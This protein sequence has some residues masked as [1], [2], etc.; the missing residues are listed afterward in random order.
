MDKYIKWAKRPS[1]LKQ[2]LILLGF[3]GILFL[4]II[5]YLL[6][7]SSAALDNWLNLPKLEFGW[8]NLVVGAVLVIGGFSLGF[9]SVETQ[10]SIGGGTPVPVMPTH[11]LIATG[12]F[13]YCRNP[14]TLGTFLGYLGV[15]VWLGSISA[16]VIIL[17]LTTLLL[18]YVKFI[19]ERELE[20]R[21]GAEYLE[22]KQNTPFILPRRRR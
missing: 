7:V 5:P 20:A 13:T 1:S 18:L 12:P 19:E 15:S 8:I 2:Q 10:M 17:L 6:I 22:Y 3:A 21:F 14:M 9:W 11:R 16:I 4:I